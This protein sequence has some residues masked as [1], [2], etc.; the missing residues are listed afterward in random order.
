VRGLKVAADDVSDYVE[1]LIRR[2][3]DTRTEGETFARWAKNAEE[4]ELV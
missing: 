1:R 2:Y 4:E 3:I